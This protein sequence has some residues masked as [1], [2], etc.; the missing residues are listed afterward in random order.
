MIR[1]PWLQLGLS[2]AC[3][4]VSEIFLKIG[5]M[6]TVHLAGGWAWTGVVGLVSPLVWIGIVL[7]ILSFVTWLYV[8]RH[9]PLSIAFPVSQAVHVSVPLCGL[10]FLGE[11]IGAY[12]WGGIALVMIGIMVVAQPVATMEEKLD[13]KL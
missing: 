6:N 11:R 9:L 4:T 5:A 2:I 13:K 10:M 3:V 7:V 8:L 1:N 12:R